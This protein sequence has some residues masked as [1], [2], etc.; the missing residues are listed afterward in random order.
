MRFKLFA[1]YLTLKLTKL[2][3]SILNNIIV[4][5]LLIS[6][7]GIAYYAMF[8]GFVAVG[9][10][11]VISLIL[12]SLKKLGTFTCINVF[13]GEIHMRMDVNFTKQFKECNSD[14]KKLYKIIDEFIKD[15]FKIPSK[16]RFL[17]FRA[18]KKCVFFNTH[19]V[20]YLMMKKKL[21]NIDEYIKVEQIE[22]KQAKSKLL[23]NDLK[24]LND[25]FEKVSKKTKNYKV[26]FDI[27]SI[28]EYLEEVKAS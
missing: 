3:Y 15:V 26:T 17:P 18:Y 1:N 24:E 19:E 7:L 27:S 9:V 14:T 22:E 6:A 11:I 23:L 2:L 10:V 25:K 13:T 16:T 21:K 28:E 8:G 4:K 5:V 20:I 12:F